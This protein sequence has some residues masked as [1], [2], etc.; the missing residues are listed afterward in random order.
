MPLTVV[1]PLRTHA[2]PMTLL[3]TCDKAQVVVEL[4]H[5]RD[6]VASMNAAFDTF[7]RAFYWRAALCFAAVT[8][9]VTALSAII[10]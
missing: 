7:K 8:C 10:D 9:A 3:E 5:A 1:A 6:T 4:Q 2:Q